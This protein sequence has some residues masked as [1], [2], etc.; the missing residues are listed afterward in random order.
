MSRYTGYN[1]RGF[2]NSTVA[3]TR[4]AGGGNVPVN[5]ADISLVGSKIYGS[6][7]TTT[8]VLNASA[9]TAY[10]N[11]TINT[12]TKKFGTGSLSL[13][14]GGSNYLRI[15][16]VLTSSGDYT[17]EFFFKTN[18]VTS[19]NQCIMDLNQSNSTHREI[20]L[21]DFYNFGSKVA[22]SLNQ[23]KVQ[24]VVVGLIQMVDHQELLVQ[25][26][27]IISQHKEVEVILIT[28]WMASLSQEIIAV[29]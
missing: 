4:A 19:H 15:E 23:S 16:D 9:T 14:G 29:D 20:A 2:A 8:A 11:T 22:P 21:M 25:T 18:N 17:V 3:I 28:I 27:G 13:G 26:H 24:M 12:T 7:D 1:Q 10:G 6:F 5:H